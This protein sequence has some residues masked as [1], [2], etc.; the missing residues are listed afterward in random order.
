MKG[1]NNIKAGVVFQHTF[2]TEDDS[3]GVVDPTA[4]ARLFEC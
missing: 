3:F 4:N 1:I 2:L